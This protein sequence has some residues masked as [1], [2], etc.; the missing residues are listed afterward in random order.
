MESAFFDATYEFTKGVHAILM[1]MT[2]RRIELRVLYTPGAA[3]R[4]HVDGTQERLPWLE[5][6]PAAWVPLEEGLFAETPFATGSNREG[7]DQNP[8]A[9]IQAFVDLGHRLGL[10]PKGTEDRSAEIKALRYHLE[11]VRRVA[12]V[13]TPPR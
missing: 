12:G 13:A 2:S 9:I 7:A 1:P 8:I 4:Y 5:L 10:T 3:T 11:D 6:A